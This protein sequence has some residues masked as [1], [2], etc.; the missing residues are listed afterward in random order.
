MDGC[1]RDLALAKCSH[2]SFRPS[3]INWKLLFHFGWRPVALDSRDDHLGGCRGTGPLEDEGPDLLRARSRPG[4]ELLRT[5]MYFL[6]SSV[7][8]ALGPDKTSTNENLKLK[9]GPFHYSFND[10]LSLYFAQLFGILCSARCAKLG[11]PTI[12]DLMSEGFVGALG[13]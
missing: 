5:L 7:K 6:T 3:L 11:H 8:G 4:P 13:T 12:P 9:R 2:G 1:A 10:S